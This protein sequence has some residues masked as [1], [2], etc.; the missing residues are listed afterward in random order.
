MGCFTSL[1]KRL[2]RLSE[3]FASSPPEDHA[4]GGRTT[5]RRQLSTG[6]HLT[7]RRLVSQLHF[8][9][10]ACSSWIFFSYIST[11]NVLYH[12]LWGCRISNETYPIR[13]D[14]SQSSARVRQ[15]ERLY[16]RW[17]WIGPIWKEVA[18]EGLLPFWAIASFDSAVQRL[19]SIITAKFWIVVHCRTDLHA[20][21][22]VGRHIDMSWCDQLQREDMSVASWTI[23]KCLPVGTEQWGPLGLIY[24]FIFTWIRNILQVLVMAEM[25]F[26]WVI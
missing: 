23:C 18:A 7:F 12:G 8:R 15:G 19:L 17:G 24:G 26:M 2:Q 22:H 14:N 9:L 3:I 1:L 13:C 20:D 16:S 21:D 25:E 11:G 10:S 6:G 5:E 4:T